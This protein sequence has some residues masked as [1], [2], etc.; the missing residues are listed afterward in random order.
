MFRLPTLVSLFALAATKVAQASPCV[1]FDASF[2]LLVFGLD[3]KD[4]NAGTQGSWSSGSATDITTSGRPSF[5]GSNTT[6][7]LS[8]Y[9]NAVYV[10]NGDSSDASAVYIYDA[11]KKSWSTQSVTT[12]K[13]DP[14]NFVAVLDHDTNVF[15]AI[16]GTDL[17]FLNMG[18]ETKANSSALSWTDVETDPFPS[19]YTKPVMALAQNHIHFLDVP[20]VSAG[21]AKIF[22]I[23]YS[24]FQPDAQSYPASSGNSFP[25]AHGKTASFFQS[26]G[27]QQEFAFIPDDGSATYV[28]NV[29]NNSTTSYTG[30][31]SKDA[32]SVYAASINA[33]VQLDSSGNL[34]FFPYTEGDVSANTA[35][36]WTKV[37]AV[38]SVAP[39]SSAGA[40]ATGS[41]SGSAGASGSATGSAGGASSTGG[42]SSGATGAV[43]SRGLAAAGVLGIVG[44]LL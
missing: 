30:P 21:D 20:N 37:Q 1:S 31:T 2:N 41:H 29:E 43:V 33:L 40:S 13:F 36:A 24:Y 23:H 35:A 15:Y 39:A 5:D 16:S 17:F 44:Y 32:N 12:G 18:S 22:V 26:E 25:A 7:Y 9:Y 38:A 4:W 10:M 28:I 34:Y 27:V 19:S 6:C 3:G 14:S 11:A 42:S 8:Q